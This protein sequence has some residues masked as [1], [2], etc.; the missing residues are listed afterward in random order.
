MTVDILYR[1][2]NVQSWLIH[3]AFQF[4]L[5]SGYVLIFESGCVWYVGE[6]PS[7]Q[8]EETFPGR[9]IPKGSVN[10]PVPHLLASLS[11][12]SQGNLPPSPTKLRVNPGAGR[13]LRGHVSES[14]EG[15]E[16]LIKQRLKETAQRL[17]R[18]DKTLLSV[19]RVKA[20]S[21]PMTFMF[22]PSF[23][24]PPPIPWLASSTA[25]L[26]FPSPRSQCNCSNALSTH[27]SSQ[28]ISS[29]SWDIQCRSSCVSKAALPFSTELTSSVSNSYFESILNIS[30]SVRRA[31]IFV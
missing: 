17:P 2:A 18:E 31:I 19:D 6:P 14:T 24:S 29:H 21:L 22:T 20:G 28:I 13:W 25:M 9:L 23:S 16:M 15:A 5:R 7:K 26:W 12:P 8:I 4:C 10:L 1:L 30:V 11:L 27:V 3:K